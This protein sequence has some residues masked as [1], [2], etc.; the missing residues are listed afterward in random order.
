M[1]SRFLFLL[2]VM[3]PLIWGTP[4]SAFD[5]INTGYFDDLA[6]Q[7]FDAANYFTSNS[8]HE[9]SKEFTYEWKG[10]HWRF[11][12]AQSLD[13]FVSDPDKYSPQYGGYCSNQMSLGNL[14][15]IDPGVWLIFKE[16]LYFFGHQEGLDRWTATGIATRIKDADEQWQKYLGS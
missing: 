16:K 15:S 13:L 10:V 3:L 6:L 5:E 12:N 14:S 11:A 9:G 8:S 4:A 7:G 2:S 1:G